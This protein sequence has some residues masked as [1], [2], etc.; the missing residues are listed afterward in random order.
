MHAFPELLDR[1]IFVPTE[2]DREMYNR[3]LS[4]DFAVKA[5]QNILTL[6]MLPFGAAV[7]KNIKLMG[8]DGRRLEDDGYFWGH[9]P[10][11]QINEEMGNIQEAHPGFFSVD[12]NDYYLKH[13]ADLEQFFGELELDGFTIESV[14]P[15]FIPA[16]GKRSVLSGDDGRWDYATEGAMMSPDKRKAEFFCR[17]SSLKGTSPEFVSINPSLRN[18]KGHAL[19]Q[20]LAMAGALGCV[21]GTGFLSLGSIDCEGDLCED[22]VIPAFRTSI[23]KVHRC[24]GRMRKER[25]RRFANELLDALQAL[26]EAVS[27]SE[28]KLF[29]YL[30]HPAVLFE[31]LLQWKNRGIK[32]ERFVFNLFSGFY[33][34]ADLASEKEVLSSVNLLLRLSEGCEGISV[35]CDSELFARDVY[36]ETGAVLPFLPMCP[37][38]AIDSGDEGGRELG[39]P[40]RIAFPSQAEEI[41]GYGLLVDFVRRYGKRFS[42]SLRFSVRAYTVKGN[43]SAFFPKRANVTV[44]EGSLNDREYSELI[45]HSDA[46]LLPYQPDTFRYRTS[47]I[48]AE[49]F[50]CGVPVIATRDTWMEKQIESTGGGWIIPEWSADGFAEAFDEVLETLDAQRLESMRAGMRKWLEDNN[51]ENFVEKILQPGTSKAVETGEEVITGCSAVLY[52][53]E[54]G[55][56]GPQGPRRRIDVLAVLRRTLPQNVKTLG[57][58]TIRFLR[59]SQILKRL[60]KSKFRMDGDSV[61]SGLELGK[62]FLNKKKLGKRVRILLDGDLGKVP[63]HLAKEKVSFSSVSQFMAAPVAKQSC[64]S[65]QNAGEVINP[66]FIHEE[67]PEPGQIKEAFSSLHRSGYQVW[68]F[69]FH[70]PSEKAEKASLYR[71]FPYPSFPVCGRGALMVLALPVFIDHEAFYAEVVSSMS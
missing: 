33:D 60:R 63:A 8:C 22:F 34:G 38:Q 53:S 23:W 16:L 30:G 43:R 64:L 47:S 11:A 42:A 40:L 57:R 66:L 48:L 62:Y 5:T 24:S 27:L 68:V 4:R 56:G 26:E 35:V 1:T 2:R 54:K 12:Y 67:V 39:K 32:C 46:V 58:G 31:L 25:A 15:S 50:S 14:A 3:D 20:D 10:T 17:R 21:P 65:M 52:C 61:Q 36:E 28:T 51:I 44:I 45:A 59:R 18:R 70:P 13:C 49:A 9:N 69:Q 7:S 29:F 41:R 71:V 19:Y 37:S 6:L 55:R